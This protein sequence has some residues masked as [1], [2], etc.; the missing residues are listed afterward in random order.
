MACLGQVADPHRLGFLRLGLLHVI[1]KICE[2]CQPGFEPMG[3]LSTTMMTTTATRT[4]AVMT[5]TT[6]RPDRLIKI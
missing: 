5:T 2:V 3:V 6:T 1:Y 4:T